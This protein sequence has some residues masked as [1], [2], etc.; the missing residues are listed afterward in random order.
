MSCTLK[1]YLRHDQLPPIACVF[2]IFQ[3]PTSRRNRLWL[4]L[5]QCSKDLGP[6]VIVEPIAEVVGQGIRA[7]G[8]TLLDLG[9]LLLLLILELSFC[10][11]LAQLLQLQ[12]TGGDLVV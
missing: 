6:K 8:R 3:W 1:T 7:G 2:V 12:L 9:I 5:R 4:R 10:Q 11:L